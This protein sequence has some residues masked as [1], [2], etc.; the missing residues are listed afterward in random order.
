[1]SLL[2]MLRSKGTLQRSTS[3]KDASGGRTLAWSDV[4]GSTD[5]RCDIQPA[6]GSTVFKYAQMHIV[7]THQI[8]VAGDI[9]ARADDRFT[10]GTRHFRIIGWAP[11][12]PGYA[13]WPGK[14]DCE[15]EPS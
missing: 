9:G 15:E 7:V 1:M 13:Q 6:S 8:L 3:T 11:P 2:S 4:S 10:S 5:V 14:L 12:A